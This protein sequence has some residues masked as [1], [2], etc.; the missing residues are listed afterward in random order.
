MIWDNRHIISSTSI[1]PVGDCDEVSGLR[2]VGR[3]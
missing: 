2:Q 3:S 1:S